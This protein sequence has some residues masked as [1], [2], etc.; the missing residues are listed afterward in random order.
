[1][2]GASSVEPLGEIRRRVRDKVAAKRAKLEEKKK[3][4]RR[5]AGNRKENP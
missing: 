2:S 4:L 3:K 1:M 5:K